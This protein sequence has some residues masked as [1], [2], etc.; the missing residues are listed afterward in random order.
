MTGIAKNICGL[1]YNISAKE[2]NI[3]LKAKNTINNWKNGY[4][5]TN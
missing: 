1:V 2:K 3:P 5:C 4:T